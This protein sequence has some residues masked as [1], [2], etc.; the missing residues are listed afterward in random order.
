MGPGGEGVGA[1]TA[2][3][4]ESGEMVSARSLSLPLVILEVVRDGG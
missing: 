2:W 3:Q 1:G 4:Q